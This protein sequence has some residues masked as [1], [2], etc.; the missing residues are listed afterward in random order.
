MAKKK[1]NPPREIEGL[2]WPQICVIR[3]LNDSGNCRMGRALTG[4]LGR[5]NPPVTMH[6]RGPAFTDEGRRIAKALYS[7]RPDL[8]RKPIT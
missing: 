7:W 2:T 8:F 1:R 6:R 5:T 3:D 4:L